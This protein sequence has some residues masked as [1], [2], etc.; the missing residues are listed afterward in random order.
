M[1][2]LLASVPRSSHNE[3]NSQGKHYSSTSG[4]PNGT[5]LL[6]GLGCLSDAREDWAYKQEESAR[7]SQLLA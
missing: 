5:L 7:D 2:G 4:A 6:P 3:G 1:G